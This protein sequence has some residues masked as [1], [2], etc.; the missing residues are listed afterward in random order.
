[1][2]EPADLLGHSC[3][4]IPVF[5]SRIIQ[6][7]KPS[8]GERVSEESR[9]V[10]ARVTRTSLVIQLTGVVELRFMPLP[11]TL[12]AMD[13]RYIVIHTNPM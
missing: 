3:H 2:T 5:E 11:H 12:V 6:R 8:G 7:F 10:P 9:H 1:V 4:G 13:E